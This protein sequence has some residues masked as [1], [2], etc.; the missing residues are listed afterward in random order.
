[1]D[2][3]LTALAVVVL[4]CGNWCVGEGLGRGLPV[5]PDRRPARLRARLASSTGEVLH[6]PSPRFPVVGSTGIKYGGFIG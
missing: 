1:M 6:S 3:R 4:Q 2:T 5:E